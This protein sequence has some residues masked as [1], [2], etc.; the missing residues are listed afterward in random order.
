MMMA[1]ETLKDFTHVHNL[2][3]YM[4]IVEIIVMGTNRKNLKILDMPAGNGLL[5]DN[6]RS[7]GHEVTC[8]DFNSER[9]EYDY[10]NMEKKLPYEDA[11][12]DVIIC[13]EGIE[14][15]IEPSS[16]VSELCR[17]TKSDGFVIISLPNV[18][19]LFSRLKF[20]FT[21][22][23]YQFEPEGSRHPQGRFVDR[24]HISPLTL[25]QL[26]YLFGE[27][28]F[29]LCIVTGDK[30]KRKLLLP[31]YLIL[32]LINWIFL[33]IRSSKTQD[34]SI[35]RLYKFLLSPRCLMS[36]SLINV[37]SRSEVISD[38]R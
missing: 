27:F 7:Y 30:I 18:Q 32:W 37:W 3:G 26:Q 31:I 12:F 35:K 19:S 33:S 34:N 5:S 15:I 13:L 22:T 38:Y 29:K 36:R 4:K 2:T 23:F 14:H 25:M 28:E 6:L 24:G 16:L 21:G 8:A 9:E 10:V 11:L 20:L 17:V 1:Q